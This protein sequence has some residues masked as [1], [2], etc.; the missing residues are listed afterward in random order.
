MKL[1]R[2][3]A[4]LVLVAWSVLATPTAAASETAST[5]RPLVV[6]G[7]FPLYD[8][9][10][11]IGGDAMEVRCLVPPGGDPHSIDPTP[12]M[13]RTVS[14]AD[15]VLLMGLGMDVWLGKLAESRGSN[16]SA[17]VTSG[18]ATRPVGKPAL[19]EFGDEPVD[20]EEIDPH[21]W[22]DPLRAQEIARQIGAALRRIAPARA[23]EIQRRTDLFVAELGRLHVEFGSASRGFQRH[24][25]VTFHGAF[26][27]LFERYGLETAGVVQ[28]H[29]GT[30]PSLSYLRA[31]VDLMRRTDIDFIF[32]EPQLPD[33]MARVIA[34]E[35]NGRIERLDPCETILLDDPRATYLE[36]QR[37]N[38]AVLRKTLSGP[39]G[40]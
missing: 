10:R 6:V 19:A 5:N 33:R 16:V 34:K 26:A 17:T 35:I 9:A 31:L 25:V 36:R 37:R 20:A 24:R 21:V 15:V 1:N 13:A 2:S 39:A 27:Y 29:P 14:K 18:I 32:A 30:E 4:A 22:L 11:Q 40:P 8:F 3:F 23:P 28:I 12:E 38:L 7:F